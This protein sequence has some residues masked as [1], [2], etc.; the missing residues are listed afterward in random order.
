[1]SYL[2]KFVFYYPFIMSLVWIIGGLIFYFTKENKMDYTM[3]NPPMVSILIP[4]Y[5]EEST[6]I[7]TIESLKDLDYP[8]YEVICVNDGSSDN[9]SNIIN[10]VLNKYDKLRFIDLKENSG[11]ANALKLGLLAS[12]GEFLV[13]IDA[14]A[15]LHRNALNYIMP[16]FINKGGERVGAVTGSPVVSNRSTLL[17]KVQMCEF[18][19]IIGVIKR[20]QRLLGKVF[21][22]S[23]VLV[24]F[25]KTSLMDVGLWDTDMATEDIA[26]SWKL[27]KR[28]WDIRYEPKAKCD[29]LVPETIRGILSQRKRWSQGGFEVLMRHKDIFKNKNYKRLMPVYIEQLTSIIWT[30]CWII[31]FIY[32]IVTW[33]FKFLTQSG[34]FLGLL[35]LIQ[36]SISII[37]DNQEDKMNCKYYFYSVW[38]ALIYWYF[39]IITLIISFHTIFTFKSRIGKNATWKSPD[40]GIAEVKTL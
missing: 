9:T 39:N 32:S 18:G 6:I 36:F 30:I 10:S 34:I 23:G 27:Q 5:N 14:D 37:L 35:C 15:R 12:K 17:G 40:R 21:T 19:S 24:C 2:E 16:H 29:M 26:I 25:R 22:V 33:N 28:F 4:C 31:T 8:N 3:L 1:M 38:Y 7:K 11:K 13:C 20:A